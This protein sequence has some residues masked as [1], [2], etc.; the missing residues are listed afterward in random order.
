M[1]GLTIG[2]RR[3]ILNLKNPRQSGIIMVV[4]KNMNAG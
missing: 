4:C 1:R 2:N 3:D